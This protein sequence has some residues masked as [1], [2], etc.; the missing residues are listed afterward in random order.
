VWPKYGIPSSNVLPLAITRYGVPD[1]FQKLVTTEHQKK[2][3]HIK[4]AISRPRD[5]AFPQK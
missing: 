3:K 4:Q 1:E 2:N 5:S